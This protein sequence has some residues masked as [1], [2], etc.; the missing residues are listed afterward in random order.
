MT[1]FKRY[2]SPA[3]YDVDE[4]TN[5]YI[6]HKFVD[7][8]YNEFI[9]DYIVH[10]VRAADMRHLYPDHKEES[11]VHKVFRKLYELCINDNG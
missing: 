5:M 2:T 10:E 4:N 1:M 3:G 8:V 7:L 11:K 6:P 9:V